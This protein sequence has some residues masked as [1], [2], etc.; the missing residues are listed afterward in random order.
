MFLVFRIY[1]EDYFV[2][3]IGQIRYIEALFVHTNPSASN[4]QPVACR[5]LRF[6]PIPDPRSII[7]HNPTT[8]LLDRYIALRRYHRE[9]WQE[10]VRC[11]E[12]VLET[13]AHRISLLQLRYCAF[14]APHIAYDVRHLLSPKRRA[15]ILGYTIEMAGLAFSNDQI[16][17]HM[18]E[19]TDSI[20]AFQS[21]WV[22]TFGQEWANLFPSIQS[23]F[24][25]D[26]GLPEPKGS[27]V[28]PVLPS[29]P[30]RFV[31]PGGIAKKQIFHPTKAK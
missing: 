31:L 16:A 5:Q 26:L 9:I 30:K 28:T 11:P 13:A 21:I 23:M 22:A 14:Y 19:I 3:L 24:G 15:V 6:R 18:D 4:S 1:L 8:T 10:A 17:V 25:I 20:I 27:L 12:T 2:F 29:E 7:M